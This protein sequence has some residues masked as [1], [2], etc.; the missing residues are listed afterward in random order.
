VREALR[1]PDFLALA[2]GGEAAPLRLAIGEGNLLSRWVYALAA[3]FPTIEDE[4]SFEDVQQAWRGRRGGP[5]DGEPLLMDEAAYRAW[6]A[7]WGP[8]ADGAVRLVE[9]GE[10]LD[11]AWRRRPAWALLPFEA[12]EPRWKI[13]AVDGA[14]P[15]R[16]DFD[17][18]DYPLAL[19]LSLEGDPA[20]AQALL[21]GSEPALLSTPAANRDPGR[22]TVLA[23]TGVTALV[24]AT[25]YTME[26]R[27]VTYPAQDIS[28]WLRQA[29]LTHISNEVPF[30]RDCPFPNPVQ[31]D[32]RFCS[33]DEYIG[34]LEEVGADVIEL[35]GD[36]FGDWGDQAMRHTL[37]LYRERGWPYYGGGEDLQDGRQALRIEHNGNRLAF[38]GCNAKG[39]GYAGASQSKPGA[40][41]CDF[42]WMEAEISRLREEG[43]L[44]IATFQHFEY[45][46]YQAQ[47]NQEADSR[48]LAGAGAVIVSGSQAHQP[49]GME[50][51][52]RAFIHYGLGNLFFDQYEVSQATR[53]AFIDRHVFYD[54]RY[55]GVELL[56][57]LF[58]DFARPRPMTAG[59]ARELLNSVFAA[60]G[61]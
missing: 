2:E 36:H 52:Q 61:W 26:R 27:G 19:P 28:E 54:G 41:A 32:M 53:Q 56:P 6:Q 55:L 25:A 11:E 50:F 4:V 31:A 10:L 7:A 9:T 22:L 38:I 20:L 16:A 17:P 30:A 5:F 57:I 47:P 18:G 1:L 3:P 51:Y 29:D 13:L 40:V 43:Y 8:A 45:Y 35:T 44:P 12:I 59:E 42:P 49:Q 58:V 46:T 34:L 60:S 23:M 37:G 48:R 15:L 24:R 33:A 21:S 39:G 14:S